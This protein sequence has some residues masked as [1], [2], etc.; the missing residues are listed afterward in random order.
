M[1]I[2]P[3]T[4]NNVRTFLEYTWKMWL[5]DVNWNIVLN[6]D[7]EVIYNFEKWWVAIFKKDNKYGLLNTKGIILIDGLKSII[8]NK[9]YMDVYWFQND[10]SSLF[11]LINIHWEIILEN[12]L[13]RD[14]SEINTD[15]TF[16]VVN[17]F[18]EKHEIKY[19]IDG[20]LIKKISEIK[21]FE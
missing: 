14:I 11:G 4:F 1:I 9:N 12:N 13:C 17:P 6:A 7:F 3:N 20:F 8:M 10:K 15:G 18:D 19:K 21:Y 16:T 2:S 5:I